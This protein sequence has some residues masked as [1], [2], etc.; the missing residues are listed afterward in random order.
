[1]GGADS[2]EEETKQEEAKNTSS[3]WIEVKCRQVR[4]FFLPLSFSFP[5]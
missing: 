1:M 3:S 5:P 2:G 4:V